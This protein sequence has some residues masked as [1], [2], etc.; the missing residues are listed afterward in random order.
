MA[1]MCPDTTV[2]DIDRHKQLFAEAAADL[3]PLFS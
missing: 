3:A 1:L 2:A